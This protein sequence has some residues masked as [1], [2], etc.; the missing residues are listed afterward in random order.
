MKEAL[1]ELVEHYQENL[2][3]H[4]EIELADIAYTAGVGR[5]HFET[6]PTLI[7]ETSAELLVKLQNGD[8]LTGEA[9]MPPPKIAFL[10]TGQGSQYPRMGKQLYETQP[11]FKE[12]LDRCAKVLAIPLLELL[13]SEDRE[14]LDQTG[15]T[16]PLLFAFEYALAELWKSWGIIPDYVM[17][18]SAGEYVAA[19]VAGIL[20]LEDG[21]KLISRAP[22]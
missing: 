17:G 11:V 1:Q 6:R 15:H 22:A 12:A 5:E 2:S 20:S 4:P 7:A 18:H 10:F 19:T 21:L 8:Y 13:Q 16:Q 3:S 14:A 9:K